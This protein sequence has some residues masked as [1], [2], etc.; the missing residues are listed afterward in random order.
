MSGVELDKNQAVSQGLKPQAKP[1]R[2]RAMDLFTKLTSGS[3]EED[4][5]KLQVASSKPAAPAFD[6]PLE[7]KNYDAQHRGLPQ[8]TIYPVV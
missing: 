2:E 3:V 6:L 1:L 8:T 4:S 7:G 5:K